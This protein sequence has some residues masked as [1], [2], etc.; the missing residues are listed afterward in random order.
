MPLDVKDGV[1]CSFTEPFL[2]WGV[3]NHHLI[4]EQEVAT[5]NILT[6]LNTLHCLEPAFGTAL[7][8]NPALGSFE[9]WDYIVG[10]LWECVKVAVQTV[11]R[12]FRIERGVR[13]VD[14]EELLQTRQRL[15]AA[16]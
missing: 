15:Y 1:N 5:G 14:R 16:R 7:L 11:E 8:M 2:P 6:H 12:Q 4:K 13:K 10:G 3:G 9:K